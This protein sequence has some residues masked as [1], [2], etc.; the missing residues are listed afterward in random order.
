MSKQS[1]ILTFDKGGYYLIYPSMLAQEHNFTFRCRI[2]N[3][4]SDRRDQK[5][6]ESSNR[7]RSILFCFRKAEY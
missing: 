5:Q 6:E 2:V 3:Q 1:L 7:G 4:Q